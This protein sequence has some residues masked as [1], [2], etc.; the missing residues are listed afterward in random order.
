M[1][2]A[3]SGTRAFAQRKTAQTGVDRSKA[4]K[5]F[6]DSYYKDLIGQQGD[7]AKR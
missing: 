6:I 5:L 3:P 7:R 1:A 2:D 4:A